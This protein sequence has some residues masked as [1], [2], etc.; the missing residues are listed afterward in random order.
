MIQKNFALPFLAYDA[1]RDSFNYFNFIFL[2]V[3][4]EI[5]DAIVGFGLKDGF[6]IGGLVSCALLEVDMIISYQLWTFE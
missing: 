6:I 2:F 5:A 3:D 1:Q 4:K